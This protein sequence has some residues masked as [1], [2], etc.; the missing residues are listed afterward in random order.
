MDF[1]DLL[2]AAKW[3]L[4]L[5][6]FLIFVIVWLTIS[7]DKHRKNLEG[8]KIMV[9]TAHPDDE[10]MFF[11]PFIANF[12]LNNE[13]HLLCLSKGDSEGLGKV[14]EKELATAGSLLKLKSSKVIDDPSLADG[15]QEDWS[16]QIVSKYLAEEIANKNIDAI[17]TFDSYGVSGHPNHIAVSQAS[18]SLRG[19]EVYQ[20][21][22]TSL[23]RK[24]I[25]ILDLVFSLREKVVFLNLNL[26]LNWKAMASHYS[27]FVWYRRL[28]VVFSRYTFINT[29]EKVK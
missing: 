15:M 17:V 11:V 18:D 23:P 5:V 1:I 10:S 27:Q 8:K 14:R 16:P 19:V 7:A 2:F 26:F 9:A 21:K 20:L 13:V 28:F 25:G 4:I 24:Y 12:A 29:F 3:L 22:S 6:Q